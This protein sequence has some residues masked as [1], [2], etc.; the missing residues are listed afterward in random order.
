MVSLSRRLKCKG[1]ALSSGIAAHISRRRCSPT[2]GCWA[3][4]WLAGRSWPSPQPAPSVRRDGTG[5][6]SGRY[7]EADQPSAA[8][9][10]PRRATPTAFHCLRGIAQPDPMA[11]ASE[12]AHAP[13]KADPDTK[14]P[15]CPRLSSPP[16]PLTL[17]QPRGQPAVRVARLTPPLSRPGA[18][19]D[20]R[21]R[22]LPKSWVRGSESGVSLWH[23]LV[24]RTWS[25]KWSVMWRMH[26]NM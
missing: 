6:R 3:G 5:A 15:L 19:R 9:F 8:D 22:P 20:E 18:R 21:S 10:P 17:R 7:F 25:V 1:Q 2:W 11:Q 4:D 14:E 26:Y 24:F 12:T 23:G 13:H 16:Q